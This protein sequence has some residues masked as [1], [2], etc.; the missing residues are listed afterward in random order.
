MPALDS[1][2]TRIMRKIHRWGGLLLAAFII[3]YC[4]TGILLNHRKYFSYFIS[5]KKTV[6]EVPV[7][8]IN[9]MKSFIDYYKK[10]TGRTDDP[11]VIRIRDNRTVEFLYGSH[12]RTTYI[13]HPEEGIMEKIEKSP[14]QPLYWLNNLHKAFQTGRSWVILT[15]IVSVIIIVAAITGLVILRYRMLDYI[16]V[17]GGVLILILGALLW[18]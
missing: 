16:M 13:I 2:T 17:F 3:F 10:Q 9:I 11:T 15:D 6:Y 12:G 4:I 18:Q 1:K 5:K 8:D 7:S 14:Q